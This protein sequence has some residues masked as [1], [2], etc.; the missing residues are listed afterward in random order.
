MNARKTISLNGQLF[1]LKKCQKILHT[2]LSDWEREI[3]SFL[4]EWFSDS[5]T[6]EILTSGSTG[7]PK[8]ITRQKSALENSAQLTGEFFGF[9]SGLEILLCL[10]ARFIAGKMMLVRAIVW[11]LKVTYIEPKIELHIPDRTFFFT[12]MTPPQAEAN[13]H[14]LERFSHI[15]VGGAAI[16]SGLENKL[17]SLHTSV[18]ETF[19]MTETV[20]H[21]AL[22]KVGESFFTCLPEVHIQRNEKQCLE[23]TAPLLFQGKLS[24]NDI[25]DLVSENQ[26]VWKGRADYVINSGGIKIS[27]EEVE[28]KI[29]PLL[30]KTFLI[31]GIPDKKWGEQIILLIE[32][33]PIET[34]QLR[35]ELKKILPKHQVPSRIL[36]LPEFEYTE[37]GKIQRKKTVAK[38]G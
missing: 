12:A 33:E 2:S 17:D 15:I 20:S 29:S 35:V 27:P 8:L 25:V 9:R 32:S 36:F 5:E 21:I 18:Y 1:D 19:G 10:P 30:S 13:L 7:T 37:N 31:A 24:T 14:Q 11:Q 6:I 26:F 16:T 22:R 28:K 23:I 3:F 4:V 34:E 38:I